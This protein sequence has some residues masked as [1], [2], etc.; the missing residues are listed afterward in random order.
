M[1]GLFEDFDYLLERGL[2]IQIRLLSIIIFFLLSHSRG[3]FYHQVDIYNRVIVSNPWLVSGWLYEMLDEVAPISNIPFED[4]WSAV[5][6]NHEVD[7]G[8]KLLKVRFLI[9]FLVRLV[10]PVSIS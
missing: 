5:V 2:I 8:Q 6:A 1:D 10:K 3:I 7:S 9:S 4:A